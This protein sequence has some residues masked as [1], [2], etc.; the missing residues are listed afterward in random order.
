MG[1]VIAESILVIVRTKNLMN[2]ID[3]SVLL[4]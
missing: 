4:S 3:S 2:I 1:L